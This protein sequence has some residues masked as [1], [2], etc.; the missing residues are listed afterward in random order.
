MYLIPLKFYEQI[1][2]EHSFSYVKDPKFLSISAVD[3]MY[4]INRCIAVKISMPE[5]YEDFNHENIILNEFD[6]ELHYADII[7][8]FLRLPI[9]N[10]MAFCQRQSR[11][12]N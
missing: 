12:P 1:K 7:Q 9:A 4:R 3:Q 11:L 6:Q 8:S 2:F 10:F 5:E